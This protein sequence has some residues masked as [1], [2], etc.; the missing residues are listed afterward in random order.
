[1]CQLIPFPG[2]VHPD[3]EL[4]G[5]A[6]RPRPELLRL[7]FTL[8]GD[9]SGIVIDTLADPARSD[10]LWLH[11]CFEAFVQ[12]GT[13][14]DYIEINL[15]TSGLWAAYAF[16]GYRAGM[17]DLDC[18]APQVQTASLGNITAFGATIDLGPILAR[19][20]W[21]LAL[22]AVIEEVDG[23]KS[24]WALAH[25]PG[26]PDFHHPTCFAATLPPPSNS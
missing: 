1:M 8:R 5:E 25:P 20:P 16:S 19:E 4:T 22:S 3:I 15:A 26:K 24:Y 14:D 18:P 6:T 2:M 9:V 23:T 21:Q 17:R 11:T 10:E 7:W 13:G 12:S